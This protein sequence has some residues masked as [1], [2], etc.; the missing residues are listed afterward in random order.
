MADKDVGSIPV[1][2]DADH[3]APVGM[4][5][6]RDIVVRAV[7]KGQDAATLRADQCMSSGVLTIH[8]YAPLNEAVILMEREQVRR[9][10]V[11]NHNGRLVGILSQGDV[12]QS[13]PRAEAGELVSEV[14][15]PSGE[16]AAQRYH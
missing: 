7:A 15:E 12:A 16:G 1:V 4:I 6:D 11:V 10:M 9:L 3:R 14:S 8:E 13:T 5:T 2:D